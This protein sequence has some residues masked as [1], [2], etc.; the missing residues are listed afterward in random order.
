MSVGTA[1]IEL[2]S[3]ENYFGPDVRVGERLL[4]PGCDRVDDRAHK[5]RRLRRNHSKDVL[6]Q[7]RRHEA[8]ICKLHP[9]LVAFFLAL[10]RQATAIAIVLDQVVLVRWDT[11]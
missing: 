9:E 4:R 8:C 10:L 3:G 2:G 7:E 6:D 11:Y 1:L 5:K